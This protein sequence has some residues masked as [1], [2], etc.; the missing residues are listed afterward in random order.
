VAPLSLELLPSRRFAA[1]IVLAYGGAAA[2]AWTLPLPPWAA[3]LL[4]GAVAAEGGRV[5]RLRI[6]MAGGAAVTGL[7]WRADGAWL[8]RT[9]DGRE[10]EARL[11]PGAYVHP[12]LTVLRLAAERPVSVVLFPDSLECDAFR[13]L[14]VR[15]GLEGRE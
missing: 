6:L 4:S 1:C 3:L 8:V 7:L 2:I 9:R 12:L 10:R 15:L 14:R 11:L 5:F 13:R